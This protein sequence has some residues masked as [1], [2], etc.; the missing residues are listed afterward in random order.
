MTEFL[1]HCRYIH[2]FLQ[3]LLGLSEVKLKICCNSALQVMPE[4]L[5]RASY[6]ELGRQCMLT[7]VKKS[8]QC[9]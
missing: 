7:G 1:L 8:W 2:I 5:V 9:G 4:I 6:E 3:N